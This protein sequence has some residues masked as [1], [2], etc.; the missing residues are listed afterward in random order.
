MPQGLGGALN[1][2]ASRLDVAQLPAQAKRFEQPFR[3]GIETRRIVL[4]QGM[5]HHAL[6]RSAR[7]LRQGAA[8]LLL[9]AVAYSDP[10]HRYEDDRSA[11]VAKH[12]AARAERIDDL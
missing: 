1:R 2:I 4:G 11:G 7:G 9:A 8:P 5:H 3:G 12:D 6:R 10:V